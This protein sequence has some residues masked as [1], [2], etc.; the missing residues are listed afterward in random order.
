MFNASVNLEGASAVGE[1]LAT[2]SPARPDDLEQLV[3]PAR[4]EISTRLAEETVGASGGSRP[5]TTKQES[6]AGSAGKLSLLQMAQIA[7]ASPG[8]WSSAGAAVI[9]FGVSHG[10]LVGHTLLALWT[11]RNEI[12]AAE[13][14]AGSGQSQKARTGYDGYRGLL[15]DAVNSPGFSRLAAGLSHVVGSIE[16]LCY[17]KSLETFV[18]GLCFISCMSSLPLLNEGYQGT[19]TSITR[20]EQAFC[21]AWGKLPERMQRVLKET[22]LFMSLSNGSLALGTL[23]LSDLVSQPAVGALTVAGI[24][25][26]GLG[27][28]KSVYGLL[29]T[30]EKS[31]PSAMTVFLNGVAN[32]SLS[33]ASFVAGSPFVG[34]AKACWLVACGLLGNR[35]MAA[36]R[37]RAK[38][39]KSEMASSE[40]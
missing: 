27:L 5:A 19:R 29:V 24:G 2:P 21:A 32:G 35:I 15:Y 30:R 17:G 23:N 38:P 12:G 31:G 40:A 16:A 10:A 37:E 8:V 9:T 33:V 6:G 20:A 4:P 11:A 28:V 14:Q 39:T 26:L 13:A 22:G 25:V 1:R 34:A 3:R 7:A 36:S 18:F